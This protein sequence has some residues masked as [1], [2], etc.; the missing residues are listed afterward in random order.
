MCSKDGRLCK[1]ALAV[2]LVKAGACSTDVCVVKMDAS[3]R[4]RAPSVYVS[5]LL[6][7]QARCVLMG[8]VIE[9]KEAHKYS[10]CVVKLL[11]KLTY[12]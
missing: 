10:I 12:V 5:S 1:A 6:A 9:H 3:A 7:K 11:V 2:S 8:C 4:L